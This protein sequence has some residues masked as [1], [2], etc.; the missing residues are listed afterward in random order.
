MNLRGYSYRLVQANRGAD[1]KHIGV[2]LGKWCIARDIPVAMVADKFG[3]SRMT[4]YQ[5]F[6]G[7]ARPHKNN[8]EQIEKLLKA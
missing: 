4:I 3:V 1:S 8:V 7:A 5:W 6:T 2:R